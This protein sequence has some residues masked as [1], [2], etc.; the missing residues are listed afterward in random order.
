MTAHLDLVAMEAAKT[1]CPGLSVSATLDT[2]VSV[3]K[4][5]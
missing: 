4:K 1:I 5:I 2:L 3:A